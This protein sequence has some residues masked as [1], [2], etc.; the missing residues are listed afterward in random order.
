MRDDGY[1]R[2]IHGTS[3]AGLFELVAVG[4]LKASLVVAVVV[5]GLKS[6]RG[7][8]MD[9]VFWLMG[10]FLNGMV[11]NCRLSKLFWNADDGGKGLG[12]GWLRRGM[13]MGLAK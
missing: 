11:W 13:W 9:G 10:M 4:D 12:D 2:V 8:C 5:M 3:S 7:V 6:L 1:H